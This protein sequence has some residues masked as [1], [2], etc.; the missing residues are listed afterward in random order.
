[1]RPDSLA[2]KP[3]QAETVSGDTLQFAGDV[4]VAEPL[5][6]VTQVLVQVDGRELVGLADGLFVP[7]AG[8][9]VVL[10]FEPARL[11]LFDVEGYRLNR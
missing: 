9:R 8:S 10:R 5:G 7:P 4:I 11:H 1:M 2:V 3:M 6:N